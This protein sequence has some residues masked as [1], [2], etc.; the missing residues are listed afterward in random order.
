VTPGRPASTR[1]VT[2]GI[3]SQVTV[4]AFEAL[5][6]STAMPVVAADLGA[7]RNYG[8]AFSLFLTMSLLGTVLS[9]GWSDAR[10]PVGPALAGLALFTSG[11]VVSG[12]ATDFAVFLL[13][14]VVSGAG[15]GF[16]VVALYVLVA[17]VYPEAARPRVFGLVSAAW[18]LPS[19]VGP[20]VAGWL[21]TEVSWRA[22]FLL[23]PPLVVL[24]LLLLLRP[25][26]ALRLGPVAGAARPGN[27]RRRAVLGVL[28]AVGAAA[29]QW[30]SQELGPLGVVAVAGLAG[31]AV[32]VAVSLPPL[33]PPGTLRAARGLPSVVAVRGLLAACFFGAETYVPLMLVT[34]RHLTPAVAGLTLTGGAVGWSVGSWLQGR[35]ASG[36]PRHLLLAGGG[37][38]VGGAVL[39]LSSLA[40]GAVPP[41]VVL[42]LWALAG[43]GMGLGMSS[44]SVLVLG[45]S[46][47]GEEGRNSAALQ[48]SDALGS[49][50]GIGVAGA[51][52]AALHRPDASDA[53][54]FAGIWA[55]LSLVGLLAVVVGLRTR[56]DTTPGDGDEA[57]G[58]VG[59]SRRALG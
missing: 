27:H 36:V 44:T 42:P 17:G 59:T 23:V 10:G 33:L 26:R 49:V 52:F 32:L 47:A 31:G 15:A 20:P 57:R 46:A 37:A 34:E 45:L 6:V 53:A 30:G 56:P 28:L 1:L 55:G 40:S 21:A 16:T 35:P 19:V 41:F 25:L 2:L 54:T 43:T 7:V 8:L 50:T 9:G 22:V 4:V 11:A 14:R 5:A 12:T 38:L 24:A 3:V 51:V 39:A 18:V 58:E 29:A 13:G 48:V